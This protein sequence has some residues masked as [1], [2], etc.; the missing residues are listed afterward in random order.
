MTRAR[1][2]AIGLLKRADAHEVGEALGGAIKST[3]GHTKNLL[4]GTARLGA[5]AAKA[6]GVPAALGSAVALTGL[7]L[8]AVEGG[9]KVK[10]KV[11]QVRAQYGLLPNQ[12]YYY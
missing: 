6:L 10:Q 7:G 9:R 1:M 4:H 8:G 2:I 5:G 12:Q 11:D 3:A